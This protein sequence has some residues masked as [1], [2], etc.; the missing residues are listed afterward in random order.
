MQSDD[1][2]FRRAILASPADTTLKL[3]YADWLQERDDLRAQFMRLQV[4]LHTTRTSAAAVEAAAWF[5]RVGGQLDTDWVA[6]I[7]KSFARA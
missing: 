4:E 7:R 6:F 5:L 3:V 1:I 2:A